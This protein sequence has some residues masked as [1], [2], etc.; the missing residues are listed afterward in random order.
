MTTNIFDQ[1]EATL[2]L[3][4][5]QKSYIHE[6]QAR[7]QRLEHALLLIISKISLPEFAK[8]RQEIVSDNLVK[9]LISLLNEINVK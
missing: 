6:L 9:E 5:K 3:L 7:T 4:E 8:N 1:L 2:E